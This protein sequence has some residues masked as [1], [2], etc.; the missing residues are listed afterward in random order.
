MQIDGNNLG[1]PTNAGIAPSK[2]PAVPPTIA[3]G[4][5]PLRVGCGGIGSFQRLPHVG[6]DRASDQ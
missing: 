3:N 6:R 2:Y 1:D 4:N 5:D